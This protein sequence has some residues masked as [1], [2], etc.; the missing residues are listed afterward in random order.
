M[1]PKQRRILIFLGLKLLEILL[2]G[3]GVTGIVW[4]FR[5]FGQIVLFY[6]VGVLLII[7]AGLILWMVVESYWKGA[8]ILE[9][10]WRQTKRGSR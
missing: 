4:G 3:A 5:L 2:V 7:A 9:R 10:S 1:T 8:S 6:V